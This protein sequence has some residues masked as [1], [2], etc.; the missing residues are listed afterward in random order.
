MPG[1]KRNNLDIGPILV[2]LEQCKRVDSEGNISYEGWEIL[3]L[4]PTLERTLDFPVELP[5]AERSRIMRDALRAPPANRPLNTK[6]FLREVKRLTESYTKARSKPFI[7]ATSISLSRSIKISPI[8][9]DGGVIRLSPMLPVKFSREELAAEFRINSLQPNPPSYQ[10]VRVQVNARST[11]EAFDQTKEMLEYV[12]A[13]WNF[14]LNRTVPLH[15]GGRSPL[16]KIRLGQVHTLHLPSGELAIDEFLYEPSYTLARNP[17]TI[18]WDN[19]ERFRRKLHGLITK[20]TY[21]AEIREALIRYGCAL[22]LPDHESAFIK[23]WS[24]LELL[25]ASEGR[26]DDVV[27]R[28]SFLCD[29]VELYRLIL[30]QLRRRQ[31]KS[32]ILHWKVGKL[33]SYYFN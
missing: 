9:L 11:Y 30:Q 1:Q 27:R 17:A 26:H 18:H 33:L 5:E 14:Q 24:A 10:S 4:Y 21:R 15:F 16:N 25:T 20:C 6:T 19:I 2:Q 32:C 13:I 7:L 31:M 23:L 29:D 3:E 22:D 8:H 28:C 12:R